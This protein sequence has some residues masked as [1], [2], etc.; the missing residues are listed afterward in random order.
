MAT[1]TID[2]LSVSLSGNTEK[3]AS[4]LYSARAL[5][6]LS[7]SLSLSV[8]LSSYSLFDFSKAFDTILPVADYR[9]LWREWDFQGQCSIG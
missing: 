8:G 6:A 5:F 9:E 3:N 7:L 4:L 2:S 1:A